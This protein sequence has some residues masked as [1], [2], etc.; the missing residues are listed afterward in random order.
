MILSPNASTKAHMRRRSM[1]AC[2]AACLALAGAAASAGPGHDHGDDA[3]AATGPG[4]GLPRFSASSELFELVGT[5]DGKK[6]VL[7]LDH[8]P[9]NAPVKDAKLELEIGGA[10]VDVK[11]HAEGEYEATLANEL[12]PGVIPV[13]ATVSTAKDSDLLAGEIDLHG[14]DAPVNA[15]HV[16]SWKKYVWGVAGAAGLLLAVW[17]VRRMLARKAGP[18]FGSAA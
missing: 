10:K 16:H 17:L 3:P 5:I 7:Y 2:A 6:L 11:P 9:S 15:A 12:A 13:T 1:A 18:S 4:P 8:A 14:P